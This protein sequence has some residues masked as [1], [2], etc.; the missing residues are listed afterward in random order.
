ME[1]Y[2][3]I[4]Q[5]QFLEDIKAGKK[6]ENCAIDE[7]HINSETINR[8]IQIENCTIAKMTLQNCIFKKPITFRDVTFLGEVSLNLDK[9]E[10]KEAGQ[11]VYESDLSFLKCTFQDMLHVKSAVFEKI[12]TFDESV[13]EKRVTF[14]KARFLDKSSFAKT[15]FKGTCR[16]EATNF[17]QVT[18]FEQAVF[19]KKAN[20][21]KAYFWQTFLFRKVKFENDVT[22]EN[23]SFV[24]FARFEDMECAG[25]FSLKKVN[26]DSKG[27]FHRVKLG[28]DGI[29]RG[30]VA[31]D[32][33]YFSWMEC[34]G[35]MDFSGVEALASFYIQETKCEGEIKFT[36]SVFHHDLHLIGSYFGKRVNLGQTVFHMR[37]NCS[38]CT[39]NTDVVL[40]GS[41]PNILLLKRSQIEGKIASHREKEFHKAK[42]VYVMLRRCFDYWGEHENSE[43]AYYNFRKAERKAQQS[44]N[45]ATKLRLFCNWLFFDLGCG[46]GTKPINVT[47]LAGFLIFIFTSIF[48][49]F[50][51]FFVVDSSLGDTSNGITFMQALYVS[52]MNFVTLGTEGI[53][54][55]FDHWI[56]YLVAIEGFLGLFLMTVFV[57]TYTRKMAK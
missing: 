2:T 37:L 53:S 16:F 50:G 42:E 44:S 54:P 6:L 51:Q 48:W 10:H 46:Y 30:I 27:Y 32:S 5:K 45:P 38:E 1:E 43:W 41:S 15:H 35:D 39:F 56:K 55:S 11:T 21:K 12:T 23:A 40:Y 20:F 33:Q 18:S 13:F 24:G 3:K 31:K 47:I 7:I 19:S 9:E 8:E 4:S 36:R 28:D 17:N 52:S 49:C 22:F 26:M 25:K 34:M 29:F 57:G 14:A